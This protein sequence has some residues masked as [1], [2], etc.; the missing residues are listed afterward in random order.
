MHRFFVEPHQITEDWVVIKGADLRH[1]NLVLRMRP[2]QEIEVADGYGC[3]YRVQLVTVSQEQAEGRIMERKISRSEPAVEVVLYQGLSKGDKLELVIQ[4]GVEVGVKQIIPV[5]SERTVIQWKR[6][7][8][9]RLDRWQRVAMEAA[10][11][12]RRGCIP[13]VTEPVELIPCL[14][15]WPEGLFGLFLWEEERSKGLKEVLR[16]AENPR[17]VAL[18]VGPE[19][20]F[21]AEEASLAAERGLIPVSLGPRILRTETAG[22]VALALVLYELGDLGGAAGG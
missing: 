14:E 13:E 17:R 20:G 19:G 1:L 22:I 2:G 7:G 6:S 16:Q 11:Q 12:S 4:K 9:Q 5:I 21:T 18:M 3:E 8:G 10:K 15:H